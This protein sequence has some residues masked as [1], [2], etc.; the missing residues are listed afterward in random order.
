MLKD[1]YSNLKIDVLF[2][3]VGA[4]IGIYSWMARKYCDGQIFMFEPDVTNCRLLL[5]T[6][7]K[8]ETKNISK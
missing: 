7:I 1:I 2:L 6:M 4:N 5:K 3:D 8:T